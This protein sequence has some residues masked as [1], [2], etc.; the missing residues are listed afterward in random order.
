MPREDHEVEE[1]DAMLIEQPVNHNLDDQISDFIVR[2]RMTR[3]NQKDSEH[4]S[5]EGDS[6]DR[7][8]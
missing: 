5:M 7:Q 6:Q 1:T 2:L 3:K 8:P 4:P